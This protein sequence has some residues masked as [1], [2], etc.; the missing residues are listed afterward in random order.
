[1]DALF[2]LAPASGSASSS[3]ALSTSLSTPIGQ[4]WLLLLL[5]CAVRSDAS[6]RMML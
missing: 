1:M 2:G 3:S 6:P 5:L 4:V